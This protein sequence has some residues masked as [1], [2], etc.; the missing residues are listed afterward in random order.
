M[1]VKPRPRAE[2]PRN[3]DGRTRVEQA[4]RRRA[5]VLELARRAFLTHGYGGTTLGAIAAEAG[6]SVETIHKTFG[7]KSG[8]VRAIYERGLAGSAP[9]PAPVR[10]DTM[11]ASEPDPRA[12]M[13]HWGALTA[14]VAPL[15]APILLLVR[16]ASATDP[17]LVA[18]LAEADEQR[19]ARMTRNAKVLAKRGFLRAGISLQ[20][21][22]DVMWTCTAPELYELL[23]LRRGWTAGKFGEFVGKT[24]ETVLLPSSGPLR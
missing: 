13:H 18:L 23:V 14:E 16:A 3:Y 10:S 20:S 24:L 11:S 7:G 6:V 9:T 17:D 19:L 12:L 22:R 15:V 4:R 2:K 5:H 8:L 1:A 21:A